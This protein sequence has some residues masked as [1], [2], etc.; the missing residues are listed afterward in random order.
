MNDT[1]EFKLTGTIKYKPSGITLKLETK[2]RGK[3]KEFS[4][5][6]EVFFF[7]KEHLGFKEGDVVTV[8]GRLGSRKSEFTRKHNDKEYPVYMTQ[9]VG[10]KI[11][12]VVGAESDGEPLP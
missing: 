3:D 7:G 12:R 8:V 11:E 1:N 5:I 6:H 10:N 2:S 9:A 4:T